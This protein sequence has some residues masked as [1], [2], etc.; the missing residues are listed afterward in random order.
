MW[1][2][3]GNTAHSWRAVPFHINIFDKVY[4]KQAEAEGGQQNNV[5][6]LE[7]NFVICGNK[8]RFPK[9]GLS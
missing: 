1:S 5:H 2:C 7:Y 6:G 9:F 8:L 4:T 3:N